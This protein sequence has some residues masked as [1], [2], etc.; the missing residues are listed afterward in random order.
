MTKINTTAAFAAL[1]QF[2]HVTA[3]AGDALVA[4]LK[5]AGILTYED[6]YPVVTAWAGERAGCPLVEG[7]R[8]AKGQMVLDST[9]PAYE[10]AK[11]AR[12]R[13]M[14]CF[15]PPERRAERGEAKKEAQPLTKAEIAALKAAIEACGGNVARAVAGMRALSA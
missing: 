6:A 10:G 3:T 8:K 15:V 5:K 11:T 13:V 2:A 4:A 1:D 9:S 12:R 14:D 7:Q